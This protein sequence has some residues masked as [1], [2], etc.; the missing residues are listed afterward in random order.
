M[1]KAQKIR[2][3]MNW[4]VPKN[5]EGLL[6]LV[7][8]A[9]AH[10]RTTANVALKN[11]HQGKRCFVLGNGPSLAKTDIAPLA[12]EYTI[13]ANSFYRHP[14][15]DLVGLKYLC[16]GDPY[17]MIERPETIAWHKT[18]CEKMPG[19]A[20]ILHRDAIPLVRN[21][22]LYNDREVYFVR[23]GL[24]TST[25]SLARIDFTRS[26]NIGMTTGTL[27][28]IPLAMYLGFTEIYLLGFDANWLD[29][30]DGSYHFYDKH[31]LFPEFDSVATDGRGAKYED[32]LVSVLREYQ[33]HRLLQQVATTRRIKLLN[34][35]LGGRLDM[36]PRIDYRTLFH[37]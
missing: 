36:H 22:G 20:F 34:A 7:W 24:T 12:N 3:L 8:D 19:T 17:F 18:L 29:N 15:A 25:A 27:V 37:G 28:A 32:E 6:G 1:K 21:N 23:N 13:G 11:R 26:L 14:Q 9:V 31:E 4:V 35:T 33:S 10:S 30:Y 5:V 16:V 2:Q